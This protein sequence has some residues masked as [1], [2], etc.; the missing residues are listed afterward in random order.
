MNA[1]LILKSLL[2]ITSYDIIY[3]GLHLVQDSWA[4]RDI[5]WLISS[6]EK[7]DCYITFCQL[8]SLKIVL[9]EKF[10]ILSENSF[11]EFA[12]HW[13]KYFFSQFELNH[14]VVDKAAVGEEKTAIPNWL[15]LQISAI[16]SSLLLW[17]VSSTF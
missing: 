11:Y 14:C 3:G 8:F 7:N 10:V 15:H 6:W 5:T 13:K 1:K 4:V 12:K 2:Q 9:T 16:S 17:V